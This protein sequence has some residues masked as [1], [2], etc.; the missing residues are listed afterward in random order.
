MAGKITQKEIK[1]IIKA[2]EGTD[3]DAVKEHIRKGLDPNRIL[4]MKWGNIYG[5]NNPYTFYDVAL[6]T[7]VWYL[8]FISETQKIKEQKANLEIVK[9]ITPM[10]ASACPI[11]GDDASYTWRAFPFSTRATENAKTGMFD[12][13]ILAM[14]ESG[15]R[16]KEDK[17]IFGMM[18]LFG[19]DAAREIIKNTGF[20][21]GDSVYSAAHDKNTE[22]LN[23]KVPVNKV[24]VYSTGGASTALHEIISAGDLPLAE[25]LLRAG[26]DISLKNLYDKNCLEWAEHYE[27]KDML[28]LLKKYT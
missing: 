27:N 20:D 9:Y 10:I 19:I 26:A 12:E 1:G 6:R 21:A 24:F 17:R 4:T 2:F 8:T 5:E 25:K 3:I 11:E 13:L 15:Y 7:Q 18:G 28:D 16:I 14:I 22:V 23:N